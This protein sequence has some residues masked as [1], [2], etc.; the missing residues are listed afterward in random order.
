[1]DYEKLILRSAVIIIAAYAACVIIYMVTLTAVW[2]KTDFLSIYPP[3][4]LFT[5]ILPWL[6]LIGVFTDEPAIS[7]PVF[8][9]LLLIVAYGFRLRNPVLVYVGVVAFSL[10]WCLWVF[11]EC[12]TKYLT[13]T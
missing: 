2:H 7:V 6:Q 8:L 4:L 13:W 12:S 5:L 9:I 1:M 10:A 11:Y 3:Q